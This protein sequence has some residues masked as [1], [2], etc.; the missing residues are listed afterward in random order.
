MKFADSVYVVGLFYYLKTDN[1]AALVAHRSWHIDSHILHPVVLAQTEC[2]HAIRGAF[3]WTFSALLQKFRAS[4]PGIC[5]SS[6]QISASSAAPPLSIPTFQ[7][8]FCA[9]ASA[10]ASVSKW[11]TLAACAPWPL[12]LL[13]HGVPPRAPPVACSLAPGLCIFSISNSGQLLARS[14]D[15]RCTLNI[16]HSA[17]R[18]CIHSMGT[19]TLHVHRNPTRVQ[20]IPSNSFVCCYFGTRSKVCHF[21]F[22]SVSRPVPAADRNPRGLHVRI[23][24]IFCAN[25][26]ATFAARTQISRSRDSEFQ[27]QFLWVPNFLPSPICA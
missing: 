15:F 22:F 16:F 23:K 21:H 11:T 12:A 2:A 10:C 3:W 20:E 4:L 7:G 18:T 8:N 13:P 1:P 19:A 27:T 5:G 14:P 24:D 25:S 26:F 17:R 9:V 6:L